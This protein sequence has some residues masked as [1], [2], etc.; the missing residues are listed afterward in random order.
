MAELLGDPH[1]TRPEHLVAAFQAYDEIRRP[2]SQKVVESSKEGAY[3]L[4]LRLQGV[5]DDEEKLKKTF[6]SRFGWLWDL[7]VQG[8]AERARK[9]MLDKVQSISHL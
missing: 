5:N 2:R 1:V 7:D 9:I 3:L 8:Q 6:Q 4:C